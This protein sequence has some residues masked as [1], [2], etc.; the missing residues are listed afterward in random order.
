MAETAEA[1]SNDALLA[2]AL[3]VTLPVNPAAETVKLTPP[4][5]KAP[6]VDFSSAQTKQVSVGEDYKKALEQPLKKLG[7]EEE[8]R[9]KFEALQK[10]DEANRSAEKAKSLGESAAQQRREILDD[11]ARA[12]YK[13]ALEDKAKPFI[14]HQDNAQDLM[15]LFG[16]LNVVGFAIGAS[17]K[18]NAQAAMSAMNGMLEGH[19]KGRDDLYKREKSIFETNQKQLDSRIKQLLAFMQDN[20]LLS[21]M[22]KTARDQAIESKFLEDGATFLLN[23]YREYG[24]GK[25]LE[26]LKQNVAAMGKAAELAGKEQQRAD[27]NRV[28]LALE[29]QKAEQ[30]RQEQK[31]KILAEYN[32]KEMEL[33]QKAKE[34]EEK[35]NWDLALTTSNRAHDI[36]MAKANW[37]HGE[38]L[39]KINRDH[40]DKIELARIEREKLRDRDTAEARA[41]EQRYRDAMLSYEKDRQAEMS[42]HNQKVEDETKRHNQ[43]QE[44]IEQQKLAQKGGVGSDTASD[45]KNFLG[46]NFG[47]GKQADAKYDQVAAA[48]NTMAEAM[49]LS[50][51]V[52][53][54]PDV[55]GR[56]GQAKGFIDRYVKSLSSDGL[57]TD[58]TPV[59]TNKQEQEALL[60][61]KRYAAYLIRYEQALA[62]SAKGF[63]VA[64]MK[65][66]NEL[67]QQSQFNPEGFDG[68]MKE[69]IREIH[70]RTAALSTKI[71]PEGMIRLGVAQT[72]D[73]DAIEAMQRMQGGAGAAAA[74]AGYVAPGGA[75]KRGGAPGTVDSIDAERSRAKAA[76]AAG[77]PEAAVRERFKSKTGQ[78]L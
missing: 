68:L 23:Y 67:M 47:T 62:G 19:Q 40:L 16:L 65:R 44:N 1:K 66:F 33:N 34:A 39:A 38:N 5:P 54:N 4:E 28:T 56:V 9:L 43:K 32:L 27:D 60:F 21:N 52:R 26:L 25:S 63:T 3:N 15:M 57:E 45:V 13:K 77:A 58:K 59:P 14:P 22:D 53:K 12:E 8:R 24:Y 37:E 7:D 70:A 61:S 31:D 48:A 72:R 74:A 36:T 11:P 71:T 6:P 10:V 41:A 64:F 20:E 30:R 46:V 76:I 50:N 2:N 35:R 69:Q 73:P 17:G 51:A 29:N 78:E 55:V 49:A 18:E 42:R 75:G